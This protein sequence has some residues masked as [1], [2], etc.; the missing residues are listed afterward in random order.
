MVVVSASG[1][2]GL[3]VSFLCRRTHSLQLTF[4]LCTTSIPPMS[5]SPISPTQTLRVIPQRL[6]APVVCVRGFPT[7]V[8]RMQDAAERVQV[9]CRCQLRV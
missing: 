6:H 7:H 9:V 3:R 1:G 8:H 4:Q 2:A 5:I